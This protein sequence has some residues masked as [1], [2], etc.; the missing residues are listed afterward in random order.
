MRPRSAVRVVGPL[1]WVIYPSLLCMA[2]T[3]V[4]GTPVRMFGLPLPEPVFPLVLA[5][6]WPLIR[7]SMI[8]PL[9]LL[10]TGVFADLYHHAPLGLTAVAAIGVYGCVLAARSFIVGQDVRVLFAWWMGLLIVAF[11]FDYLFIMLQARVAPTIVGVLLQFAPTAA[12][13]P[14]AWILYQRFDDVD[15]RFR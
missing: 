14:L 11:V 4:F 9:M 3:L 1:H 6:A 12:L 5:F 8:G 7:P 10:A 13:F 2:A 15:V